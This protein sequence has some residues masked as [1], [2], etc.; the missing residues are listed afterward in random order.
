MRSTGRPLTVRLVAKLPKPATAWLV[1][2]SLVPIARPFLLELSHRL[3]DG[4]APAHTGLELL[5]PQAV[6]AYAVL[7]ALWGTIRLSRGIAAIQ[8]DLEERHVAARRRT[9]IHL[10]GTVGPLVVTGAVV[11][12]EAGIEVVH[13]GLLVAALDLPLLILNILPLATFVWTFL[14]LLAAFEHLGRS[15]LRLDPFPQDR[16]LGLGSVG[17]LAFT[18][19][20]VVVA[21]AVPV[22]ALGG[23][24]VGT[25][26]LAATVVVVSLV[27]LIGA[28]LG[29]HR[30]MTAAKH[31]YRDL[32]RSV[33]AEA[34]APFRAD[35]RLA[36]LSE[37]ATVLRAAQA[38]DERAEHLYEWPIDERTAARMAIVTTGVVTGL[39]VRAV[40]VALGY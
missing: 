39:I 20:W 9:R 1:A 33:F 18:G 14:A 12:L 36:V 22:I 34:Y 37:Q 26:V 31:R 16:T 35:P 24:E 3:Q 38:L 19:F 7:L 30:Q 11:V 10:H 17:A 8:A 5:L 32:T 40:F 15:H 4:R 29:I 23:R 21:A 25:I 2:W 13:H 6:Q 27:A 28:M